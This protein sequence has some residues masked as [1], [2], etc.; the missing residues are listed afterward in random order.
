MNPNDNDDASDDTAGDKRKR[1]LRPAP[2]FTFVPPPGL[3]LEK[4]K[5]VPVDRYTAIDKKLA[6]L[7]ATA[8]TPP[9]WE[10]AWV[11][12]KRGRLIPMS[13]PEEEQAEP[14]ERLAVWQAVRDS[15]MLPPDA[16]FFLV[17]DQVDFITEIHIGEVLEQIDAATNALARQHGLTEWRSRR[18]QAINGWRRFQERFP[19]DWDRVYLDMLQKH[20]E[21]EIA[22]PYRV[23]P[24]EF[25][26]KLR[27]G[28]G[29]SYLPSPPREQRVPPPPPA[30]LREFADGMSKCG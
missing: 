15:G 21:T 22:R 1:S 27:R 6:E 13:G 19:E 28:E 7:V 20:G 2:G 10:A 17:A 29:H 23:D 14:E 3:D 8:A 4:L 12:S 11:H 30:W 5:L 25:G 24:E 26:S 18:R 16:G 9:V